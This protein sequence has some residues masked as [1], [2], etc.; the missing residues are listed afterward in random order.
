VVGGL[1]SAYIVYHAHRAGIPR[2]TL[3]RMVANVGIDAA[4]GAFP[5]VGDLFDI[6]FQANVRNVALYR[7]AMRGERRVARDR[8]F[9]VILLAAI[10]LIVAV[11]VLIVLWAVRQYWGW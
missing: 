10:G 5:F 11:P 7:E 3:L 4:L 9:L 1:V 6:V 8:W 2:P